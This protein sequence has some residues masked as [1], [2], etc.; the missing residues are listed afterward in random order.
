MISVQTETFRGYGKIGTLNAQ[1]AVECRF[2]GEVECV[3]AVH[4]SIVPTS[5]EAQNGEVRYAGRV[6]FII[7]YEDA[8]KHV[9]RA[10]KGVEFSARV[11][12]ERCYPALTA[13][14]ALNTENVSARREGASVYVT[15]LIGGEIVLYGEQ[16]FEY[17]TGGDLVL[18]REPVTVLTAHL[19]GGS[20]EADDEFETEFIGDILLHSETVNVTDI[21]CETGVLRAEGEINLG[22]LALKGENALVSFERL[23][24][25]N[26]EIPC[27]EASFGC[28]AQAR[29][30]VTNVSLHADSD[31]EKGKCRITAELTLQIEG[32]V[33]E[34]T[35]IDAVTDAFSTTNAVTLSYGEVECT[36]AGAVQRTTERI[37]GKA[38]LS[39][40][41]DFSDVL[42]AVVLQR[43]EAN[44]VT[45]Q[46]G[47]RAE[48]IAS[49]PLL[50]LG[51][52]GV[53]R[54][55]EMSLPFSVP[56]NSEGDCEISVMPCGM[57]ARQ[58][59]EGEIDAEAT[60]KITLAGIRKTTSRQ[61][62]AVE[63]G[64]PVR[65]NDCA[66]SVYVPRAGDGLWELAKS[67]KKTPEEVS[68]SNPDI[69]FPIKEGQRVVIYRK[70]SL[71]V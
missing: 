46:D 60:L 35:T 28:T 23:V 70:K 66:V 8:E 3:L 38:A 51:S 14:A 15:A 20:A 40:A 58:K 1:T 25:F 48:G 27:D 18:K 64:A 33:Y 57:S 24:P 59:Q 34:E 68:A 52:D 13:R 67:L 62:T 63:E 29:V 19:C 39:S 12:D 37:S 31:E 41:V 2:G 56:V 61:V 6:H 30:I 4:A 7:V 21:S 43:A 17:L 42:Q 16:T 11:Q 26:L 44:L 71:T 50:V 36:G 47:R 45:A 65:E 55:V 69:E 53:R 49:A 10:E 54:G 32:C 5:V 9:C 22:V